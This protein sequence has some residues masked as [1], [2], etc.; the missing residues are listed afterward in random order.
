MSTA[1]KVGL[2]ATLC[3]VVLAFLIMKVEDF[4]WSGA[5]GSAV[6]VGFTSVAGLDDKASVRV[7][8]VRV[9]KVDGIRLVDG[10]ARVRLLLEQE[11]RITAGSRASLSNLGLLGEKYVDLI[12]GPPDAALLPP[13]AVLPGETPMSFDQAMAKINDVADSIQK[14]TG[15]LDGGGQETSIS[16][17]ISNLEATSA[18]IRALVAAN[19]EQVTATIENFRTFSAELARE[20]PRLSDRLQSILDQVDGV[21]AENRDDLRGSLSNIR[22]VTDRMQAS[23]DN[24]NQITGK[25]AAGEGTIGKLVQ[26]DQAH[27]SLVSTLDSIEGGVSKLS[28]TLGKAEKLKLQLG[29]EGAY[30][31]E[32]GETRSLFRLDADPQS[33]RFYRV[34]VVDDPRGKVRRKTQVETVTGPDGI[35]VTTTTVTTTT[36]DTTTLSAQ[37]GFEFGQA[38]LRAG[39]VESTGGA[40]LDYKLLDQRLLL[41]LDAFDFGR[42]DDLQ[43]HLR[44]TGRYSLGS[45]VYLM[46]GYDDLLEKE[47]DSL[48]LGAGVRWSDDD[49]KYLLSS[50][51][52]F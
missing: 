22:E 23:I 26:S 30:L 5:K 49:L 52:K 7:A 16:R 12:L 1:L 25:I 39:L 17:L 19:R 40:G 11:L 47:R 41:S 13:G 14:L 20:L 34:E 24:L 45:N 29:A 21:V 33:G 15:S 8:G 10:Q 51:P 46:G 50:V 36:E 38:R 27:D 9:G 3:L 2:F 31:S 42:E 4:S 6:E 18:D 37:F 35:P 28:A 43:P 44:L 48:F 32:P